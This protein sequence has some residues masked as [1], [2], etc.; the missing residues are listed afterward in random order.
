M[1]KKSNFFDTQIFKTAVFI[2]FA[3]FSS[4]TVSA[5]ASFARTLPFVLILPAVSTLFYNKK[6][7]SSFLVLISC[8]IFLTVESSELY[9]T[10]LLSL[11]AFLFA[12]LGMLIKR[13]FVTAYVSTKKRTFCTVCGV[14]L[15]LCGIFSYSLVFGNPVSYFINRAAN[16][17]YIADT[18]G[19][20]FAVK[21]NYTWYDPSDERYYTNISFSDMSEMNA[22]ISAREPVCDGYSN[23]YEYKYLSARRELIAKFFAENIKGDCAVRIN[24]SETVTVAAEPDEREMVFDVAFYAQLTE[25]ADF[26][27]MCEKYVTALSGSDFVC[28]KIN[29][30]GG[31]ADE[32]LYKFTAEY[33]FVYTAQ[34]FEDKTVP[35]EEKAF[36]RYY[37]ELDYADMW[38]YGK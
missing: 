32:F 37:N 20:S 15:T 24:P 13:F 6:I 38:S 23:Y 29:F 28:K 7:L 12:M 36:D 21:A 8:A 25:K 33:P 10:V 22:D 35:F 18:Y 5:G 3:V 19:E 1:Q 27:A 34:D 31:F 11:T 2:I 14:V 26:A 17:D 9:N 4:Y 30:Y 16:M